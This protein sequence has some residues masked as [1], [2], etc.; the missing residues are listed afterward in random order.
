METTKLSAQWV[1]TDEKGR[2]TLYSHYTNGMIKSEPIT[3]EEAAKFAAEF[4]GF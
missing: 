1:K 2:S 4:G 3:S